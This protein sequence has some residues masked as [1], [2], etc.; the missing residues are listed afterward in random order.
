MTDDQAANEYVDRVCAPNPNATSAE[1]F[2]A[3]LAY[4]RR[5]A[6]AIAE[7]TR[8]RY[9]Q[10]ADA[11]PV[12]QTYQIVALEGLMGAARRIAEDIRTPAPE[13]KT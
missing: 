13:A 5:R 7:A 11:T 3:G 8:E 10:Q 1:A 6:T 4:E 12:H 2:L 9:R